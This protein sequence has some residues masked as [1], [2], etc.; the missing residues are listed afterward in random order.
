MSRSASILA[1]L[2]LAGCA[3]PLPAIGGD[4]ARV[5][6][7]S[8]PISYVSPFAG[9]AKPV[10]VEPRAWRETNDRVRDLGGLDAQM[11][12]ESDED[13]IPGAAMPSTESS[14]PPPAAQPRA[15]VHRH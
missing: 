11:Q 2:M 5:T 10:L 14:P 6:G 1:A 3:P 7:P 4:P 8:K 12:G 15:P 9:Y 13:P